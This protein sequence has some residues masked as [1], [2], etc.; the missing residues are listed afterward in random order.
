VQLPVNCKVIG[1]V[2][3]LGV[4]IHATCG[5][6]ICDAEALAEAFK[7]VPQDGEATLTF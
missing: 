4:G 1:L 6:K 3:P 2:K 5:G 7:A